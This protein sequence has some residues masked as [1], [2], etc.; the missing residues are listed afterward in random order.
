MFEKL[1]TWCKHLG[2]DKIYWDIIDYRDPKYPYEFS[3]STSTFPDT[4][5]RE[6]LTSDI[7]KMHLPN[8]DPNKCLYKVCL[9]S[10][11]DYKNAKTIDLNY[12]VKNGD[13]IVI[14]T[15]EEI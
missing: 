12:I 13:R 8:F 6:V 7:A 3:S 2:K 10:T 1:K 11:R 5:L 9:S 4:T 14:F 15:K